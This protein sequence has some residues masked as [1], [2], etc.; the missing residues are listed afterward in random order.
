MVNQQ[1]MFDIQPLCLDLQGLLAHRLFRIPKYQRKY[2]WSRR[3]RDELYSDIL[4]THEQPDGRDHFMA[5]IVGLPQKSITIG[6]TTYQI[7]EIVDGQ[8]RITT[9]ILLLKAIALKLDRSNSTD[10][11]IGNDIDDL[12]VVKDDNTTL[13]LKTNNGSS[14]Y[15]DDYIRDGEHPRSNIA[16]TVSDRQLLMAMEECE[17]FV[18]EW[19]NNGKSLADLMRLLNNRL[20]F[21][22]HLISEESLVYTVF[23]VLN[24]RGLEVSW[25]DRLK[26][27]LMAILFESKSEIREEH[28][29]EVKSIWGDIYDCV[30]LRLGLSTESLRFAA[31]LRRDKM[32][33]RPMGEEAAAQLLQRQSQN[34]PSEVIETAKWLRKVTKALDRLMSDR[35]KSAVRKILHARLL[36]TAILLRTDFSDQERQNVIRKW[37]KVTFLIYGLLRRDSRNEVGNYV[38]LAWKV[39][40]YK[41]SYYQIIDQLSSIGNDNDHP[42]DEGIRKLGESDCYSKWREE[43][44]YFMRRYEEHLCKKLGQK[45]DNEQ[46]NHIW[47]DSAARSIEH[48][49]PQKSWKSRKKE[50]N[51][52]HGLGNLLLLPPG[53]NSQLRDTPTNDKVCAYRDTGL[54]IAK[55]V[56]DDITD[57]GGWTLEAMEERKERLLKWARKEWGDCTS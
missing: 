55:E 45:F 22:F 1:R 37:E 52:K 19:Q 2:S 11:K 53:L 43:L 23:E 32:P 51:I 16:K 33:N 28:I 31:T 15:F 39:A 34:G 42:L 44:R 7:I 6:A 10:C 9:L 5:T 3:Q 13:L 56:A 26:S 54:Q 47:E 17:K 41:V 50:D 27:M 24:N 38:R 4:R 46:W 8:Q 21:I 36:A 25:F 14:E 35:R 29:D 20:T 40:N 49:R 48:I 18:D 30:G 12:L 57:A